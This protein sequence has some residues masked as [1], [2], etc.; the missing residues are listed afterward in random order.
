MATP[1]V[2]TTW[3]ALYTA[4]LNAYAD[5]VA[6]RIQTA[7]YQINTGTTVRSFTFQDPDKILKA[8][9]EVKPLADMESGAA[10]GRTFAKN[11]GGRWQ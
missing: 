4:L 8:I 1:V 6:N 2:F 5:F 7:Q 3:S 10:V 9:K 11:G